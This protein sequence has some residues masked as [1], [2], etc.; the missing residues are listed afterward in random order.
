MTYVCRSKTDKTVFIVKSHSFKISYFVSHMV[1]FFMFVIRLILLQVAHQFQNLLR[2]CRGRRRWLNTL[3]RPCAVFKMLDRN[4]NILKM[5]IKEFL[6]YLAAENFLKKSGLL[7]ILKKS[8][9]ISRI[10]S[11]RRSRARILERICLFQ[12]PK[13]KIVSHSFYKF[14][15][16]LLIG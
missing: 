2:A 8:Q 9:R 15:K 14:S 6:F 5:R 3:R 7:V 13:R 12:K 4:L 10:Y 11:F 1:N 16:S